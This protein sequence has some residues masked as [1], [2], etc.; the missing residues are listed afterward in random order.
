MTPQNETRAL[1]FS[2]GQFFFKILWWFHL[3]WKIMLKLQFL[4]CEKYSEEWSTVKK[5]Y[6]FK[7]TVFSMYFHCNS[8]VHICSVDEFF[9]YRILEIA[10]FTLFVLHVSFPWQMK[11]ENW[12]KSF[13]IFKYN[14]ESTP[15][16]NKIQVFIANSTCKF[17]NGNRVK[18]CFEFFGK[19]RKNQFSNYDKNFVVFRVQDF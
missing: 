1:I 9:L 11:P 15:E 12:P 5:L 8:T 17:D 6:F 3:P 10:T 13:Q 4:K 14:I 7:S 19:F 16:L 18:S 2:K